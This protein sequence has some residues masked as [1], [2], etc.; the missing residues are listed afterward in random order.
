M[1]TDTYTKHQIQTLAAPY[2][3]AGPVPGSSSQY[4]A[5]LFALYN[6]SF[7]LKESINIWTPL[8]IYSIHIINLLLG[9]RWVPPRC[10]TMN[11]LG[12]FQQPPT[13]RLNAGLPRTWPAPS[14][15]ARDCPA[16][17]RLAWPGR[18]AAAIPACHPTQPCLSP[19]S[20][21]R[22]I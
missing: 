12:P 16:L 17:G 18:L 22:W 5:K 9:R 11:R 4:R 19:H 13:R 1:S 15:S 10:R 21:S 6:H 20:P 3:R 14:D 7:W 8:L 2:S